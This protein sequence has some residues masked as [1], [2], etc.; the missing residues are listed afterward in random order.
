MNE[1]QAL[2]KM[3]A[4]GQRRERIWR[5]GVLQIHVTRACDLACFGCTQGSNLG[6]KPVVMPLDDFEKACQSLQGYWGVVG[7]FGGN[8]A[9][10]PKFE[11]LCEILA[12][13]FP[14]EQRGLWCNHPRGKGAIMRRTFNPAVSNL[15]VHLSVEAYDEFVRDWPECRN[16]LKGHDTD[17][18]HSP[19][20]VAL[21][22]VVP[23]E[24]ERWRLIA[25]CDINRHWSA[26]LCT[27]PGRG[28]RA[29]FC[30]LAGA[31]AMLHAHDPNWPDTGLPAEPGWWREGMAEFADQ[32]RFHCHRCGI[33]L[34][35]YGQLAIGGDFEE[36]SQAHADI[37]RL[38]DRQRPIELVQLD[39]GPRL[40]KA[41]D[42]IQNGRLR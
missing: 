17:S 25:D 34:R 3:V 16:K 15:N 38:K 12:S 40:D 5:G 9:L 27:V 30:E 7:V 13:Y 14:F 23:D 42:Y 22:D 4:P 2:T 24:S 18:R 11:E 39:A 33:P 10:H 6:G 37:Y 1:A 26:M 35:R 32:V 21:Q 41:T 31:Q 8:P 19:P 29:Y 20:F 36:V 28:L